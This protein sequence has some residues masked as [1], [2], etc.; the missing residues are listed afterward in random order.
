[1]RDAQSL[2]DRVSAYVDTTLTEEET[3]RVLGVVGKQG[4]FKLSAAIIE[5]DSAT[6]LLN[7]LIHS[8]K[9]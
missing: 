7:I 2:L 9:G 5:R 8:F 1:M 4:L 3:G 6:A